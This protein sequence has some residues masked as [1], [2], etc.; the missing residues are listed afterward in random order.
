M[1]S[2]CPRSSPEGAPAAPSASAR[3][4]IDLLYRSH[5]GATQ[6]FLSR[7]LRSHADALDITHDAFARLCQLDLGKVANPAGLLRTIAYRLALNLLRKRHNA[8]IDSSCNISELAIEDP[9]MGYWIEAQ[10]SSARALQAEIGRLPMPCQTIFQMRALQDSSY[11][12]IS[13][14]LNMPI[15]TVEKHMLQARRRLLRS[16][17]VGVERTSM[18][19]RSPRALNGRRAVQAAAG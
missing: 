1:K 3:R 6:V 16:L 10:Q 11:Q 14:D 17:T 8:R 2:T 4:T 9:T 15:S 13:H 12:D 7:M 5:A 18:R 19:A